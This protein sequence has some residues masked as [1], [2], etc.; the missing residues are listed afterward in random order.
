M[1]HDAGCRYAREELGGGHTDAA[2][3]VSDTYNMHIAA[4]GRLGSVFA[5]ALSDGTTDG[6]L[7]ETRFD[8][9]R[10]Q[11]HNERWYCYLR[12]GAPVMTVC[13]AESVMRMQRQAARLGLPDRDDRRGGLEVIPRLT[14]E[15]YARQLA[16]LSGALNLPIALGYFKER[17]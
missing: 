8:A 2:K 4:G 3:R 5:A 13:Q 6:V 15:G 1:P 7:Y 11:R 12:L 17:P 10:H 9:V 16:A 14:N